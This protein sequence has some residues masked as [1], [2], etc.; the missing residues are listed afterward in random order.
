MEGRYSFFAAIR[1]DALG[2]PTS[3]AVVVPVLDSYLEVHG[4]WIYTGG[5]GDGDA[6]PAVDG[7]AVVI[8]G[9]TTGSGHNA[10]LVVD[11]REVVIV[12]PEL[13]PDDRGCRCSCG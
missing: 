13:L 5:D 11:G 7:R 1:S 9:S 8:T 3:E 2:E 6:G 4:G 12:K 10:T